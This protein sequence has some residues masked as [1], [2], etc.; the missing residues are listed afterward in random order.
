MCHDTETISR[1]SRRRILP[2]FGWPTSTPCS[3]GPYRYSLLSGLPSLS[4][5]YSLS[6]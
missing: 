4:K 3:R 5:A 1:N 2:V 6:S